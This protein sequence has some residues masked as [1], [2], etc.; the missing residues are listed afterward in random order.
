MPP[1]PNT[2][3]LDVDAATSD[4]FCKYARIFGGQHDDSYTEPDELAR[5]D[6]EREPAVIALGADDVVI[7]AAS[8]MLHGYVGEGLGRFRIMH[9]A[10]RT[11]YKPMLDRLLERVPSEARQLFL[12]LPEEAGPIEEELAQA[13]FAVTRRAYLLGNP[14]P[15]DARVI[16]PPAGVELQLATIEDAVDWTGIINAAFHGDP[17][18]YDMVP[19]GAA[20]LLGRPRVIPNGTLIA[21]RH[22]E[23]AGL[24]LTVVSAEDPTVAEIESLAVVPAHQGRGIGKAL[25]SA[26]LRAAAP[27]GCTSVELSTNAENRRALRL[28]LEADF[29]IDDI[30]VCWQLERAGT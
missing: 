5:F 20:R 17:G 27:R 4:A 7:G 23:P 15:A 30:R 18:R 28:Y 19:E 21:L 25:L 22:G 6:P 2:R 14:S 8:V 24:V 12:F 11:L 3:I 29:G 13:G 1:T 9:A 10:V 26:A 16:E